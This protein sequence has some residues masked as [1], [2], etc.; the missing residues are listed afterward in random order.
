MTFRKYHF[1]Q[2]P[3][4]RCQPYWKHCNSASAGINSHLRGGSQYRLTRQIDPRTRQ[5]QSLEF[6]QRSLQ[7]M[8]V[9]QVFSANDMAAV[10]V[11]S[12]MQRS[13]AASSSG[14]IP[15]PS[16]TPQ[17]P[18]PLGVQRMQLLVWLASDC[19]HQLRHYPPPSPNWNIPTPIRRVMVS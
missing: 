10:V 5:R 18:P 13:G 2:F 19:S 15:S 4:G 16:H 3:Q 9:C 8:L 17:L 11:S 1:R 7:D 14:R 12:R 6:S